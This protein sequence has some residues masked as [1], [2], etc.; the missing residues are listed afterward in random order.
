MVSEILSAL[1]ASALESTLPWRW[2]ELLP[3]SCIMAERTG[4]LGTSLFRKLSPARDS[5][6]GLECGINP[7]S[8]SGREFGE[9]VT[10]PARIYPTMCSFVLVGKSGSSLVLSRCFRVLHLFSA[11]LLS[12]DCARPPPLQMPRTRSRMAIRVEP[13]KILAWEF[14]RAETAC[15]RPRKDH[16][17]TVSILR[18]WEWSSER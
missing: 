6:A 18:G 14:H 9:H 2:W 7:A 16:T 13:G 12:A 1:E 15:E 5:A 8:E 11:P 17:S 3:A 10:D 4:A